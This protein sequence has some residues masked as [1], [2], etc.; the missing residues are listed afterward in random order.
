DAEVH[1]FALAH[2]LIDVQR[3]VRTVEPTDTEVHDSSSDLRAVIFWA[4]N[5]ELIKVCLGKLSGG[6]KKLGSFGYFR[7]FRKG[8]YSRHAVKA[9][10]GTAQAVRHECGGGEKREED[11]DQPG[12][13][14]EWVEDCNEC[15]TCCYCATDA[16]VVGSHGGTGALW[17]EGDSDGGKWHETCQGDTE[18][19]AA[20]QGQGKAEAIRQAD[21]DREHGDEIDQSQGPA[22]RYGAGQHGGFG[23][24]E[25]IADT[26]IE[27]GKG[28]ADCVNHGGE[29]QKRCHRP[30]YAPSEVGREEDRHGVGGDGIDG[31]D[32]D[33]KTC[34]A[35]FDEQLERS[36]ESLRDVFRVFNQCL[37]ADAFFDTDERARR[38]DEHQHEGDPQGFIEA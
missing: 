28:Q 24:A 31:A 36:T 32:V 30:L 18:E 5:W 1:G 10:L 22:T 13:A 26:A 4:L 8:F 37:A 3:L 7:N 35:V 17:V 12:C 34:T 14:N 11:K 25:L 15:R 38:T 23:P 9:G 6:H 27:G 16:Q 29:N 2:E 19:C 21:F 20:G 33:H